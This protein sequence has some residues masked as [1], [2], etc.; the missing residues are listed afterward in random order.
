MKQWKDET[1]KRNK[2]TLFRPANSLPN[3]CCNYS[4]LN[5]FTLPQLTVSN[6]SQQSIIDVQSAIEY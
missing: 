5:G 4:N 2:V 1:K 6:Y 3:E